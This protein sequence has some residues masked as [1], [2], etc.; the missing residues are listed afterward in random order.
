MVFYFETIYTCILKWFMYIHNKNYDITIVLYCNL[1]SDRNYVNSVLYI[2][3]WWYIYAGLICVNK[4]H[5]HLHVTLSAINV[6]Y[7]KSYPFKKYC[8]IPSLW[9]PDKPCCSVL[10]HR[11][12]NVCV[13]SAIMLWRW[14][15][16]AIARLRW[17]NDK[18]AMARRSDNALRWY[19]RDNA[20]V[21]VW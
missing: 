12:I 9:N 8:S 2:F 1:K 21:M 3:F 5:E 18:G 15:N 16:G 17:C 11:T 4:K 10:H 6:S 13:D 20:T 7:L 19:D 14:S